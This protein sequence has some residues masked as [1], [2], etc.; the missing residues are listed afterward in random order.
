[1]P[2]LARRRRVLKSET[3]DS[4]GAPLRSLVLSRCPLF[5]SSLFCRVDRVAGEWRF[6]EVAEKRSAEFSDQLC[7]RPAPWLVQCTWQILRARLR[8][9]HA[10]AGFGRTVDG[11]D[12]VED[13]ECAERGEGDVAAG[14]PSFRQHPAALHEWRHGLRQEPRGGTDPRREFGRLDPTAERRESEKGPRCQIGPSCY[15]QSHR[16]R[17]QKSRSRRDGRAGPIHD[18]Q[19]RRLLQRDRESLAQHPAAALAP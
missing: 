18:H 7:S 2:G 3:K 17:L 16:V 11:F 6:C 4:S 8:G 1:M 10:S 9:E 12:D 13:A 14:G 5:P 15:L 19:R